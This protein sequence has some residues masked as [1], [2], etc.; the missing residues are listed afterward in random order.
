MA[1]LCGARCGGRPP[2]TKED[3][4]QNSNFILARMGGRGLLRECTTGLWPGGRTAS[5]LTAF[6][7]PDSVKFAEYKRRRVSG[8]GSGY[9]EKRWSDNF[10]RAAG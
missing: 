1:R 9:T 10:S 8:R 7:L 2:T 4:F 3:A 6:L 5:R